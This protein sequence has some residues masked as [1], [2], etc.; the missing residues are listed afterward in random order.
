MILNRLTQ[1]EVKFVEN[2]HL[3]FPFQFIRK[4]V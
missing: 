2:L 4:E 1:I 3:I